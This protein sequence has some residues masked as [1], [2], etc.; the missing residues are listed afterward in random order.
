LKIHFLDSAA[1]T[2]RH[3]EQHAPRAKK[4][5]TFELVTPFQP[6]AAQLTEYEGSYVSEEIDPVYRITVEEGKLTVVYLKH[7]AVTLQPLIRDTFVGDIAKVRFT[8]DAKGRVIGLILDTGR[9]QNFAFTKKPSQG[10][11][12]KSQVHAQMDKP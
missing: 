8:R 9:I 7:K 10:K 6:T 5:N 12:A 3:F 11:R 1:A 4:I 2:P